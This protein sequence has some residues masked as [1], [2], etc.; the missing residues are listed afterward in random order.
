MNSQS[1][2]SRTNLSTNLVFLEIYHAKS[3]MEYSLRKITNSFRIFLRTLAFC[4][5]AVGVSNQ[6]QLMLL[7]IIW[8]NFRLYIKLP[9]KLRK[10]ENMIRIG[11]YLV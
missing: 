9:Y 7:L 6:E 5:L 10:E 8:I 4:H 11:Y 1:I 2:I 3:A